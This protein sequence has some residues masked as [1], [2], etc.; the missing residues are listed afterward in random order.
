MKDNSRVLNNSLEKSLKLL[1][2]FTMEVDTLGLSELARLSGIPKA[3]VYRSLATMEKY[4]FLE[5]VNVLGK[6]GQYRLGLK[7]LE[8][9][10]IVSEKLE[11]RKVAYLHMKKLRDKVNEC[12]QLVIQDDHEAIYV[13]KLESTHPVRVYTRIGRRAPL[14]G[15]ACPRAILS[16][17]TDREINDIL[18]NQPL[19]K[20]TINTIADKQLIWKS[21]MEARRL[22]YTVSYG[23]LQLGTAAVG[24]PILD[25]SG[26]VLG[27]I[28]IAGPDSRFTENEL[29]FFIAELTKTAS[30]ISRAYGYNPQANSAQNIES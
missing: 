23:E 2:Y 7:L 19:E 25:G 3:T 29:H 24:A 12:V 4:G 30:E 10:K 14:Y 22:G 28:S 8:L 16:F 9:G 15:G 27:A 6:E 21:I 1:D 17:L 11:I 5:K 13:E 18:D 20:I 26:N